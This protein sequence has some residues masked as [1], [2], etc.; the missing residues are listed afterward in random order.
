MVSWK[1]R[2]EAMDMA[3]REAESLPNDEQHM[4]KRHQL[5]NLRM[6]A[7]HVLGEYT[8]R[9]AI[10]DTLLEETAGYGGD[11]YRKKTWG[12][13]LWFAVT[14]YCIS[15][16]VDQELKNNI[17]LAALQWAEDQLGPD[18]YR[19]M[20]VRL[21][22]AVALMKMGQL[23]LAEHR[24]RDCITIIAS[25]SYGR[26]SYVNA[27][28]RLGDVLQEQERFEEA[29]E[30]FNTALLAVSGDSLQNDS[31]RLMDELAAVAESFNLGLADAHLT[32]RLSLSKTT[33]DWNDIV[34]NIATLWRIKHKTRTESATREAMELVVEG[35]QIF[36]IKF[37][38]DEAS[39]TRIVP[40]ET[41][42]IIDMTNPESFL[43][44]T[45]D[46]TTCHALRTRVGDWY[47]VEFLVRAAITLL[48]MGAIDTAERSF[49]LCKSSIE[50]A[51]TMPEDG[52]LVCMTCI[53]DYTEQ[54]FRVDGDDQKVRD[55]LDWTSE[56]IRTRFGKEMGD[57]DLK[58]WDTRLL[59]LLEPPTTVVSEESDSD[60]TASTYDS[61]QINRISSGAIKKLSGRFSRALSLKPSNRFSFGPTRSIKSGIKFAHT[62][63]ASPAGPSA[64]KI[65]ESSASR[66]RRI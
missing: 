54:Q 14:Y 61:P 37:V 52:V 7:A 51:T 26:V 35:L 6:K 22:R 23:E 36:G 9:D 60:E 29:F 38:Y 19:T 43:T 5:L 44:S 28:E 56:L 33:D 34:D 41:N 16:S 15:S 57:V 13:D 21:L 45:K 31:L 50:S 58:G 65:H 1:D 46:E 49:W 66:N 48:R 59:D 42:V 3:E 55:M 24:I 27:Y 30:A 2:Q 47:G 64:T 4:R 32:F 10:R 20:H 39:A 40:R 11:E 18:S 63:A 53:L 62:I 17:S 8:I 12:W 25:R